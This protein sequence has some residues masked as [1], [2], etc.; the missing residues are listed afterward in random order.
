MASQGVDLDL[1]VID[2][3]DGPDTGQL[4]TALSESRLRYVHSA[5]RGVG[6][7]L[8]E[9][10]R[11][12]RSPYVIRT[13]DDCEVPANWAADMAAILDQDPRA[14]L[15]YCNVVAEPYDRSAGYV[16]TYERRQSRTLRS[17]LATCRGRGLG[18]GI[19]YRRDA[20][21]SVG[22]FDTFMGPGSK[23]PSADDTDIELRVLL[24]GWHVVDTAEVAV[25]HHGFRT[26]V[27]G[28]DH[29]IRDWIALGACL[30]KLTRTMHPSAL[31]LAAWEFSAHA[32]MP[33]VIDVVHLRKP[34]GLQR[35]VSFCRG[36][37]KGLT[38]PVDFRTMRFTN[39]PRTTATPAI[40]CAEPIQS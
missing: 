23:F 15:V 16:P 12:A 25:V 9:G 8:D 26:F 3:S 39:G 17:P 38:T 35:I 29:A 18:A 10:L 37:A 13:D 7:G 34:R 2:Q 36:F 40:S 33:P 24:K 5:T 14:A 4:L 21:L 19:G 31:V 20:V 32:V 6:A 27:D 1:I 11:L 22:G 30:G 28:R